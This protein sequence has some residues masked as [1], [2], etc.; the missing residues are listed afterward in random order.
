MKIAQIND[1]DL[2]TIRSLEKALGNRVF[3]VAV[4]G[5]EALYVVEAK[6]APNV[7]QRVDEVYP[8]ENLRAYYDK[9]EDAFAGKASLKSLLNGRLKGKL[10]KRPLRVRQVE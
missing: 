1:E 10:Q 2:Q 6:L 3:L 8:M 7:W 5:N 4:E 9:K